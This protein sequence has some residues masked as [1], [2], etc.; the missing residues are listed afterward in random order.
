MSQCA[1]QRGFL[2]FRDCG[3]EADGECSRCGRPMC[4]EHL[5][6]SGMCLDCE[7]R[8]M[9]GEHPDATLLGAYAFRNDFYR[10]THYRPLGLDAATD[11]YYDDY[12][13]RGF[14]S[15][16]KHSLADVDDDREP[17]FGDS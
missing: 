10:R 4:D 11:P 17:G 5:A 15:R 8:S 14:Q 9:D 1:A 16:T 13:V 6:R 12:D 2:M 3:N 7:A